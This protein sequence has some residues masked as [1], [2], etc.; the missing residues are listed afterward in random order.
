MAAQ[1]EALVFDVFGTCVDWRRSVAGA[2]AAALGDAVDAAA[3]AD[4]WRAEYDPAMARIRDGARGYVAL[5]VLH[6]ENLDRVIAHMGLEAALDAPDRD[7]L[8]AV[9]ERLEPWPD[10]PDGLA[11]LRRRYLLAP[12]SNGSIAMMVR[13]ARH[14]RLTWDCIL[15]AEIA[16]A[17][18][19]DPAVYH[20]AAA[21][22]RLAP[23]QVMFVAAHNGDL[24][25][26][27]A[28]GMRTAFVLRPRE[29]GPGQRSDLGPED[30][31]D[32]VAD[33]FGGLADMLADGLA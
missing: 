17:Y 28:T 33:G 19:P 10:V 9:W 21:A 12:C 11:R 14:A 8:N 23:E 2:V 25:A 27:R 15:G 24:R 32:I 18:K 31:W 16:A 29:H 6:R 3:F 1:V 5:D 4:A 13:L 20:A 30:D 7:R 22:L 26:A